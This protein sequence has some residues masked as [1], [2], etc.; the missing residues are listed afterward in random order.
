MFGRKLD[1]YEEVSP[2]GQCIVFAEKL[3]VV[4]AYQQ[5]SG[6]SWLLRAGRQGK[7]GVY[8]IQAL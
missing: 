1:K 3:L 4:S 2:T 5:V 8:G 7:E 6:C